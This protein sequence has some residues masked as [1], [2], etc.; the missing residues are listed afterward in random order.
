MKKI[1][2]LFLLILVYVRCSTYEEEKHL[3]YDK[4]ENTKVLTLTSGARVEKTDNQYI[5]LGDLVLSD[6]QLQGLDQYGD[7]LHL[8]INQDIR[9]FL[10]LNME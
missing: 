2:V 7:V 1:I 4:N 9:E 3:V 8:K 5:Y 10:N 6:K